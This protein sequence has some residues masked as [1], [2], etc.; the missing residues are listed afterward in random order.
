[1]VEV[2]NRNAGIDAH[3][4]TQTAVSVDEMGRQGD[5]KTV[6]TTTQDHLRLLKW[7]VSLAKERLWAIEDCR[8]MT[9]RL[10]RD[11]IP[12]ASRWCGSRRS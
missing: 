2:R 10:E 4:R 9:R 11:L 8:H 3:K 1:M 7:A 5:T 12:L 6:G